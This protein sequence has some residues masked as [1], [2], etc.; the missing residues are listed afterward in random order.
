LFHVPSATCT[1]ISER[2]RSIVLHVIADGSGA[3]DRDSEWELKRKQREEMI[4]VLEMRTNKLKKKKDVRNVAKVVNLKELR[5]L[6]R[7]EESKED[8]VGVNLRL[9]LKQDD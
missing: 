6:M 1:I 2:W 7:A 9:Y 3:V 4:K 5:E 8:K